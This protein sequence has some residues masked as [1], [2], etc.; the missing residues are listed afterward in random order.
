MMQE[1]R[2]DQLELGLPHPSS[3]ERS[4]WPAGQESQASGNHVP[5]KLG[6]LGAMTRRAHPLLH[7]RG[8]SGAGCKRQEGEADEPSYQ[9]SLSNHRQGR[10]SNAAT[11]RGWG[12]LSWRCLCPQSVLWTAFQECGPQMWDKSPRTCEF[13]SASESGI[14]GPVTP[15]LKNLEWLPKASQI[16]SYPPG[17][18]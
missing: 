6:G 13:P 1:F 17:T 4:P 3:A 5:S 8:R 16:K 11:R 15:L 10:L 9:I 12:L 2:A 7:G 18:S 14:P